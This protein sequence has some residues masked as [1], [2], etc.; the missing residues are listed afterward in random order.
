MPDDLF[1]QTVE[2]VQ[3][4][5]ARHTGYSVDL[6]LTRVVI[7][8]MGAVTP[9]G[10]SAH[11]L[12]EGVKAGQVAI[13]P[14][15]SLPTES[16]RT[17]IAGEI[18]EPV[19]PVHEYRHPA[20]HREPTIDFALKAAEEA[21]AQ[22]GIS[23][24]EVRPERWGLVLGTC[25]A[26]FPSIHRWYLDGKQANPLLAR[27]FLPQ[28]LSETVGGALGLKG[29][30]LSVATACAAGANA[31]GYALEMIRSGQADVMLAGGTDCLSEVLFAGF[32]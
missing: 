25:M 31:L 21:I 23:Y 20:H 15:R 8:G 3:T 5:G 2:I 22:S 10:N 14:V 24:Q 17:H 28:D 11:A 4:C 6:A 9:L 7:V 27:L 29:P 19:L 26:G 32:H 13:R 12:W 1:K 30:L 16:Y 18:Q